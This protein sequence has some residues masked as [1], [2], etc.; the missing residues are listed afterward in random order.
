MKG[1]DRG[2]SGELVLIWVK[3]TATRCLSEVSNDD[4]KKV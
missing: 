3:V 4:R 1:R 2:L